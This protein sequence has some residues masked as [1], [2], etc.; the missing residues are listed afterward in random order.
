MKKL[1]TSLFALFFIGQMAFS[2]AIVDNAII[3]VAVTLNS[4]LR[5]NVTSGGNIEFQVNTLAQ[6]TDGIAHTDR[7]KTSFTVASSVDFDVTLYAEAAT[8]VGT[9]DDDASAATNQMDLDYIAYRVQ[10]ENG[11]TTP[12]TNWDIGGGTAGTVQK[13]NPSPYLDLAAAA[14]YVVESTVAGSGAGDVNQNTFSILWELGT[15]NTTGGSLLGANLGANRYT[16]N[17]FLVL[18]PH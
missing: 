16:T 17:V 5:L 10:V 4:I 1:L 9:D 6:Y 3:P 7:Y 14:T 13:V 12:V 11:G 2:Q 18:A 15:T 8:L